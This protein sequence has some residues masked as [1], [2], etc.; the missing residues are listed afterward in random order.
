VYHR[1][2]PFSG[3]ADALNKLAKLAANLAANMK[4]YVPDETARQLRRGWKGTLEAV[5]SGSDEALA[6][7]LRLAIG[8][9]LDLWDDGTHPA[10]A[11]DVELSSE[12]LQQIRRAL[13]R[14]DGAAS[15]EWLAAWV[16]LGAS[17]RGTPGG[18][19]AMPSKP[20]AREKAKISLRLKR[21]GDAPGGRRPRST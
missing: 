9:V 13:S 8:A 15:P 12:Q 3:R 2:T 11:S 6:R 1:D 21:A 14:S 5:S 20:L 4:T 7:E 10:H 17:S 19:K 18:D 16:G